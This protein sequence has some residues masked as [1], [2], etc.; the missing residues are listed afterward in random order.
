MQLAI[1]L[2][3]RLLVKAPCQKVMADSTEGAFTLLPRHIDCVARLVPGI[4]LYLQDG[5]E[6]LVAV[7]EGVLVKCGDEVRVAT[8][9]AVLGG[10]L[11]E[12]RGRIDR[13]FLARDEW[14]R[15]VRSAAARLE[16][17]LVRRFLEFSK[18][19]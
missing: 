19:A 8:R 4:L 12:L 16:S 6:H 11:G 14:E 18:T 17:S 15:K 1:W 5:Q 7:D 2:P 3:H 9:Q 13:E 10:D